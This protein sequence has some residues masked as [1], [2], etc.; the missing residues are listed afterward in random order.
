MNVV[1]M[2]MGC[3]VGRTTC[4][5]PDPQFVSNI[6]FECCQQTESEVVQ[7]WMDGEPVCLRC[8]DDVRKYIGI[9]TD[10]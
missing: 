4:C 3:L 5:L 2:C 7:S 6:K 9:D 10:G 1:F 8:E